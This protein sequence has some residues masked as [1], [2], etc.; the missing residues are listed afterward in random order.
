M[1]RL[2]A[3]GHS[4]RQIAADLHITHKTARNHVEHLYTK[5]GVHNRT[6]A[7]LAAIDLGLAR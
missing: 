5:L 7:G 1:L 6:Q 3:L 4:N 2:L